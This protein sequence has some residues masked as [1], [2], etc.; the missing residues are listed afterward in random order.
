MKI[1]SDRRVLLMHVL[2]WT[3]YLSYRLSDFPNHMGLKNGSI[4]AGIPLLFYLIISYVHYF[5]LLPVWLN[6]K[7]IALYS[8]GLLILLV[9]GLTAQVV[10]ENNMLEGLGFFTTKVT[11]Q[12]I[13]RLVWNASI[14]ILFTSMI[15]VA[16]ERFQF[17]NRK[18]QLENEKL[19]TEL[20]YL[21]A[22]INPHFLFNTL[23]NL[24][25]LVYSN[26]ANAAE[27]IVKLSNIM[28][29]MI[30]ESAK[31]KVWLR[32]EIAYMNDYIHLESIRLNESFNIEIKITGDVE[33]VKIAPLILFPFLENAFKHGV[34]DQ[35][36]DCWI[37]TDID[38]T[39][40]QLKLR[41]RNR[42]LKSDYQK[43]R[44]GFGL[45]N[46]KKRLQ[47]SYGLNHYLQIHEDENSFDVRLKVKL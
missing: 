17:E 24:N 16:I 1:I 32:D 41:I 26:S 10:V 39:E 3:F 29:Y 34:S 45:A 2:L 35:E 8:S 23:H 11:L 25:S 21:K 28:R 7:Q 22:Q 38:V 19:V 9:V 20:N 47:L 15:K 37:K 36:D 12:R 44:S 5:Y 43:E 14:F 42:K 4:Y 13:I 33:S 18:Q 30:Y 27:V 46:L 6:R 31:E 40:G